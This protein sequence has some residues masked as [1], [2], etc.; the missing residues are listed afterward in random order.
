MKRQ[1]EKEIGIKIMTAIYGAPLFYFLSLWCNFQFA[2]S[3]HSHSQVFQILKKGNMYGRHAATAIYAD[4]NFES[5]RK[6]LVFDLDF[7]ETLNKSDSV[8]IEYSDGLLGFK[9][10][11]G[12]QFK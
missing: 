6:R 12:Y 11:E 8:M 9:V 3:D 1:G 5:K 10:I 2:A 7:Q 4:I